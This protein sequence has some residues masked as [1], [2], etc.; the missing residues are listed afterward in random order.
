MVPSTDSHSFVVASAIGVPA[1]AVGVMTIFESFGDKGNWR[2]RVGK[3]GWDLCVLSV[4]LVG[5]IFTNSDVAGGFK[6]KP[7]LGLGISFS[8]LC[9]LAAAGLV[10]HV[11]RPKRLTGRRALIALA[12]GGAALAIP[13]FIAATY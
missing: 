5:G 7:A 12:L 11:R 2:Y 3:L 6:N 9:C 1:L 8:F 13:A 10:M 4:G